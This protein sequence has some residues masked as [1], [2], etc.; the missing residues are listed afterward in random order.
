MK[1]LS[2]I[3]LSTG[4]AILGLSACTKE[5]PVQEKFRDEARSTDSVDQKSEFLMT[6]SV[7][8]IS[9]T[10]SDAIPFSSGESKRVKLVLDKTA[11]RIVE[12]ERDPRYQGN[13]TNDKDV[14][15]IPIDHVDYECAKDKFGECT[16]SEQ[17]ADISWKNKKFFKFKDDGLKPAQIEPLPLLS[18]TLPKKT[19]D[20]E[21]ATEAK[22]TP[23]VASGDDSE[24]D[25]SCY[26]EV[27]TRIKSI[28][29][30]PTAINIDIERTF[31][32]NLACVQT[33]E[34]LADA[35]VSATFHYSLAKT[36]A[37]LSSDFEPV[38]YP[39][40]DSRTFGF[41]A[42]ER[43]VLDVSHNATESGKSVKMNHWNPNRKVID[44]YL[45][46]E[47]AKPENAKIRELTYKTVANINNGLATAGVQFRLNLK[48]PAG[49]NPGDIRNSMIVLVEDPVASSVI[50][51]GPQVEDPVTGEIVSART[52]MFLGTIKK[53][54]KYTYNDIVRANQQA[55]VQK[56][57]PVE[58]PAKATAT[59][60]D[61]K[62]PISKE[63]KAL[64]NTT[65]YQVKPVQGLFAKSSAKST[66]ASVKQA[67]SHKFIAKKTKNGAK[68]PA[69]IIAAQRALQ[70]V[71]NYTARTNDLY[72]NSIEGR[73][74]YLQEVKNCAY[75]LNDEMATGSISPALAA[76]FPADSKPWETLSESEKQRV[77]DIILPEIWIPTLIHEMGHNLGLRH[78]F[79]GSE[80]KDNYYSDAE[81]KTMGIDH[82]M[83]FS[84][85][86]EYGDDLK[87]LTVLGK[88]DIAALRF[89]YL[90]TVETKDGRSMKVDNTLATLS[91][92]EGKGQTAP[93]ELKKYGYCTDEHTGINAGCRRFDLGSNY[94]EITDHLIQSNLDRYETR[95]FRH[96]QAEF[97]L[98]GDIAAASRAYQDFLDL[99]L[100]QEV[101]TRLQSLESIPENDPFWTER[102]E[103]ATLFK[104]LKAASTKAGQFL[105]NVM[106]TP[107]MT[108]VLAK[109]DDPTK[110]L[111][112]ARPLALILPDSI[113]CQDI[114]GLA[115][116]S[117]VAVGEFG[118]FFNS[119]K[120][121][122]SENAYA[123]QIDIRGY[124]INKRMAAKALFKRT[125]NI[126]SLDEDTQNF[127][128]REEI[129]GDLHDLMMSQI[130]NELSGTEE[131]RFYDGT[132]QV[133]QVPYE[134]Y[135]SQ[136]I[137]KPL[138]PILAMILGL[139]N[140]AASF[141]EILA[142][143]SVA[144]TLGSGHEIDGQDFAS[145][146]QVARVSKVSS[147][148]SDKNLRSV[149]VGKE[150]L[151]ASPENE[152]AYDVL[153][154]YAMTSTLDK[155]KPEELEKIL[156]ARKATPPPAVPADL[157]PELQAAWTVDLAD[158]NAYVNGV[159][160]T[161]FYQHVLN[162]LPSN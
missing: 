8:N 71:K 130:T 43:K 27:S 2:K 9:R 96:D 69:N 113:T 4:L 58:D 118:K 119:K 80:D 98:I 99:R 39:E 63:F 76:K 158:L 100:M 107:D 120:D 17:E 35:T 28:D 44:Y 5:L 67:A 94:S 91:K 38:N 65:K 20:G 106:A 79:Q 134:T 112:A 95:N 29:I 138:F 49:K 6:S 33:L 131:V 22:K 68:N 160:T 104:D 3:L 128:D 153:G 42:T 109:K 126:S 135:E 151:V 24:S 41:F 37:I 136:V 52:V 61:S 124:W 53:Y 50:G 90:R 18:K 145:A 40:T 75:N 150:I 21:D 13:K 14:L 89:G 15:Q 30:E 16:N 60:K 54:I 129:Q 77:I 97:S 162:F 7:G 19:V 108:C 121:P 132:T 115:D 84:S 25:N 116:Y 144:Y 88:Y 12:I 83:P 122:A 51:Y 103:L 143:E 93:V 32:T 125:F 46:D 70:N 47:F 142:D 117:Y 78:N 154:K 31:K 111:V 110:A 45:S 139:P 1:Q 87:A 26:S 92:G 62:F 105:M 36:S 74:R 56:N 55:L 159:K 148:S 73:F 127:T 102:P 141:N 157:T 85:V 66:S 133:M 149:Q 137:Q 11:F 10:S 114:N 123:D 152:I 23:K 34:T 101:Y 140:R 155:T 146:F 82:A 57:A 64:L 48:D 147:I 81:L 59:G 161:D 156:D 86:M 72:D